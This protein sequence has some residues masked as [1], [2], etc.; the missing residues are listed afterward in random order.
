MVV[1][2]DTLL[3][4]A[5]ASDASDHQLEATIHQHDKKP[6]AFVSCSKL[7]MGAHLNYTMTE[8]ELL[9]IIECLKTI[10]ELFPDIIKM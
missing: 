10:Q 4:F 9:S 8:K 3:E 1:T 6:I 5:F 2:T 7:I